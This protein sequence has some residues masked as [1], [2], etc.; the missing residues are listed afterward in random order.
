MSLSDFINIPPPILGENVTEYSA[1]TSMSIRHVFM[2]APVRYSVT[3]SNGYFCLDEIFRSHDVACYQK[4]IYIEGE[5]R[6]IPPANIHPRWDL[7]MLGVVIDDNPPYIGECVRNYMGRLTGIKNIGSLSQIF[8]II[9]EK[10]SIKICVP[11][12][13]MYPVIGNSIHKSQSCYPI[14]E[15][16]DSYGNPYI[17]NEYFGHRASAKLRE[18]DDQLSVLVQ[19]TI[20]SNGQSLT[21]YYRMIADNY[22]LKC[23][24]S[25]RQ[26][27]AKYIKIHHGADI[28][29]NGT[30]HMV[31]YPN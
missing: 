16:H 22:S 18:K 1:R 17:T 3:I 13:N 29:Y 27:L 7:H 21:N 14:F 9:F 11:G 12:L 24:A 20:P 25:T 2:Y 15:R 5:P 23:S 28:S 10:Y 4:Q 30:M 8:N 19:Q 26:N 6:Y 31:I